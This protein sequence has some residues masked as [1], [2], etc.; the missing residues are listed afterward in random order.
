MNVGEQQITLQMIDEVVGKLPTRYIKPL[1]ETCYQTVNDYLIW[2]IKYW[3][4]GEM[5]DPV[6]SLKIYVA[7]QQLAEK[8]QQDI[9]ALKLKK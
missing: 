9:E 1:A 7:A 5:K 6:E 4:S 8:Y 2:K 3:R